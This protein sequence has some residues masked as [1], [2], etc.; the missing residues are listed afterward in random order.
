MQA[1]TTTLEAVAPGGAI[2]VCHSDTEGLNF[3]K[4]MVDAGWL[5]KQE[6]RCSPHLEQ[7]P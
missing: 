5:L 2:Y 6:A 3:R 7:R 1:Y 4:A